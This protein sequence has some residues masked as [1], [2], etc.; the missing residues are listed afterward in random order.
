MYALDLRLHSNADS[1]RTNCIII[2]KKYNSY[3]LT[4]I[5]IHTHENSVDKNVTEREV[6]G[7]FFFF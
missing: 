1:E 4:L 6:L 3:T 2:L 7:S 5:R